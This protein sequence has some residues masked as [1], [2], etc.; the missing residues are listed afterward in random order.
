MG[1]HGLSSQGDFPYLNDQGTGFNP[2]D[3]VVMPRQNNDVQQVDGVMRA[4]LT[5]PGRRTLDL[6]VLALGR[7]QG[8]PNIGQNPTM[9]AR[10]RT[11]RGLGYLRY[12]SRDDLGAGGR[13][14]AQLYA[15]LQRD[16]LNDAINETGLG[17]GALTRDTTE[18][19]GVNVYATRPVSDWARA[20]MVLQ[21]RH[22][23]YQRM[24]ELAAVPVGIP[25]RRLTGVVGAE[26]DLRWRWAD[27]DVIPS[28]RL[29]VMSDAI[30]RR[31]AMDIPIEGIPAVFRRSPVLRV[32][33]VRPLVD[34]PTLRLVA[35]ANVGR[36]QRV[37]SFIELYGNGTAM[38]LGNDDLV[39]EQGTNADAA[40][41]IDR[42]GERVGLVSRTTA[43]AS[44]VDDLI[45]WQ[46]AAWGQARAANLG[47]ARI[48]GVEQE[49]RLV[50]GRWGRLIG[51]GT[52]LD[53]RDR[54]ANAAAN[55]NQLPFHPRYRGYLRPE[56]LRLGLPAGL[57]LGAYADAE[58]RIGDYYADPANLED[59]RRRVLI[60]CG[61]S[62]T[63]P[64]GRLRV[65]A[66]AANLTGTQVEDLVDWALPGRTIFLTL[67]YA[68]FGAG[69]AGAAIFDPR[70]GQ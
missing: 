55:G 53:A 45:Q 41:W 66:S 58:L 7:D 61:V 34:R 21:G 26:I 23:G 54:S 16:R 40:V 9:R 24:N 32:G 46:Y 11:L 6:A 28:A 12:E 51:Q 38:V 14:A 20:A 60:G 35:K 39:P 63:S 10:F 48:M 59:K 19:A 30:S 47:R 13:L 70:Y 68:P 42:A 62:L 36:Y 18:T 57:A 64:G 17:G 2:T 43:F 15:S 29:E 31:D 4:G 8:L 44:R 56:L 67:A 22:E 49:L 25:A 65:T 50:F 3:D 5:L 33:V 52:L 37:P 27:L 69:A 1:L